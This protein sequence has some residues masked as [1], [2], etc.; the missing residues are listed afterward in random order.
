[1]RIGVSLEAQIMWLAA[2]IALALW[3]GLWF[4]GPRSAE[5]PGVALTSVGFL[6]L[7]TL[8][9]LWIGR[10]DGPVLERLV[11]EALDARPSRAP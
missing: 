6:G 3:I 9:V 7:V 10:N 1:M 2:W 5:A 4:F 11:C 8:L